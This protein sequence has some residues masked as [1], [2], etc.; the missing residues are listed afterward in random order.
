VNTTA[1][2]DLISTINTDWLWMRNYNSRGLTGLPG[3]DSAAF[4]G[5]DAYKVEFLTAPNVAA[6]III[7][8]R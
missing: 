2:R 7:Y 4:T 8:D 3:T 5:A 1:K 6:K